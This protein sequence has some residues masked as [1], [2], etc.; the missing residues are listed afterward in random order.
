MAVPIAAAGAA[1]IPGFAGGLG[2]GMGLQYSYARGFPAFEA[3]GTRKFVDVVKQDMYDMVNSFT[4]DMFGGKQHSG[5]ISGVNIGGQTYQ[6]WQNVG[7]EKPAKRGSQFTKTTKGTVKDA[8]TPKKAY[9]Q[10]AKTSVNRPTQLRNA[11]A[12]YNMHIEKLQTMG[13]VQGH[14]KYK[15]YADLIYKARKELHSLTG[16]WT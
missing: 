3:G 2:Y 8:F 6:Q 15:H 12:D 16:S 1:M 9:A 4:G 11:I 10:P 7:A 5:P 13:Y 14:N